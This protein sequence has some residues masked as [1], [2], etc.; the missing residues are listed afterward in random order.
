MSPRISEFA[1][2]RTLKKVCVPI[3]ITTNFIFINPWHGIGRGVRRE[4][5]PKRTGSESGGT[6]FDNT[7]GGGGRG[8]QEVTP[9]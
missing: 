8:G 6:D 2:F 1:I 4:T 7:F 9:R 5:L 3:S